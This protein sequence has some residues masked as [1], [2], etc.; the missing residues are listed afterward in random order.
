MQ[1]YLMPFNDKINIEEK[2]SL[3]AIRNRMVNIGNNFGK[4]EICEYCNMKEDMEHIYNCQYLNKQQ[5]EISFG[6]VYTGN[7]NE[8]NQILRI[9][10]KNMNERRKIKTNFQN[11]P[12]D[13]SLSCDPLTMFSIG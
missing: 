12:S 1:D 13:P 10:E 9:F 3:F 7:I 6:K 8:Q 5:N 11:N 4:M 2:R